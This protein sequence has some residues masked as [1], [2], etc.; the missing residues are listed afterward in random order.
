LLVTVVTLSGSGALQLLPGILGVCFPGRRVRTASG[1]L[2]GIGAGLAVLYFALFIAPNPLGI[3][4]SLW[5]LAA[6]FTTVLLVSRFTA[7]PSAATVERIHGEIE[8]FV[9]GSGR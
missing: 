1:I 5:A 6:N 4:H 8:R 7:P 3:H 2:A 9:Y